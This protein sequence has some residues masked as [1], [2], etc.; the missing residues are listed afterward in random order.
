[1]TVMAARPPDRRQRRRNIALALALAGMVVLFFLI[2][3]AKLS[4]NISP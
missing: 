1:M 4:G 2:T 3:L